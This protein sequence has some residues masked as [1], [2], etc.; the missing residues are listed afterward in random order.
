MIDEMIN[1]LHFINQL[2]IYIYFFGVPHLA[3]CIFLVFYKEPELGVG[4][5]LGMAL[6]PFPSSI[7]MEPTTF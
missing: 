6:T 1:V 4:I 7:G 3:T 5:D 2:F